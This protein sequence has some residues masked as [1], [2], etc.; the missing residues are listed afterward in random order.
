MV[1]KNNHQKSYD[2]LKDEWIKEIKK[3]GLD[4]RI[5]YFINSEENK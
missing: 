4:Y 1:D 5:D 3:E 2:A